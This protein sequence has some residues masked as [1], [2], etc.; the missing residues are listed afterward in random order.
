MIPPI[1]NHPP[2]KCNVKSLVEHGKTS[3]HGA[4]KDVG[5]EA[6]RVT[7]PSEQGRERARHTEIIA[8]KKT[9]TV[10]SMGPSYTVTM[11]GKGGVCPPP[12]LP[13][14]KEERSR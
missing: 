3:A 13:A 6:V 14:T 8:A 7:A 4:A 9:D 2:L 5:D 10:L 12:S 11:G 1:M